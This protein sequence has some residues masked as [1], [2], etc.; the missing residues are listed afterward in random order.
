[1]MNNYYKYR[2]KQKIKALE[3][4]LSVQEL[5]GQKKS[6]RIMIRTYA[7]IPALLKKM[8]EDHHLTETDIINK[9]VVFALIKKGYIQGK[10]IK[11][12]PF[13]WNGKIED[14]PLEV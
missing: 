11:K 8:S 1:M 9:L 12:E 6:E 4:K 13:V 2:Q 3:E 14:M 7:S 10:L 5:C